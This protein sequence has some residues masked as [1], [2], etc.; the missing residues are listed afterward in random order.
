MIKCLFLG[1]VGLVISYVGMGLGADK[2]YGITAIL[3]GLCM[4]VMSYS[5][6]MNEYDELT[7]RITK[8]EKRVNQKEDKNESTK[9]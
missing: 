4:F 8:L 7:D 5:T 3:I 6:A 1:V 9:T 2:W